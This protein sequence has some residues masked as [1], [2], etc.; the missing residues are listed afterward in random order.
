MLVFNLHDHVGAYSHNFSSVYSGPSGDFPK[1]MIAIT[2]S[3]RGPS[4][5]SSS[6]IV[7]NHV[8]GWI[9]IPRA[10]KGN[11]GI[12]NIPGLKFIDNFLS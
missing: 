11:L 6:M 7:G 10:Q 12:W 2:A 1:G 8:M 9:Y 4:G 5:Y 3:E